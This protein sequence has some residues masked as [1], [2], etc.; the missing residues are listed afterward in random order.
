MMDDLKNSEFPA[1]FAAATSPAYLGSPAVVERVL[2]EFL[3]EMVGWLR[4]RASGAMTAEDMAGKAN[5]RGFAFSAIFSGENA[6]YVPIVGWNSRTGGL[7]S[8][9]MA[10]LGSYWRSQRA[11]CGDDPYRVFYAWMLWATFEAMK[12]GDDILTPIRMGENI[13]QATRL[14]TGTDKRVSA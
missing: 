5:A 14:L 10:D 6:D 4:D 7:H 12:F 3:S 11:S 8:R 1:S 9:L 2:G 13:K